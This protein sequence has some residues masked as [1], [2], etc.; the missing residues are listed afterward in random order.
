MQASNL[1]SSLFC[2]VVAVAIMV[3]ASALSLRVRG[4]SVTPSAIF[5]DI[6][7]FASRAI[8]WTVMNLIIETIIGSIFGGNNSRRRF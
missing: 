6:V 2:L 7:S 8:M 3:G 4:G 1:F 5:S